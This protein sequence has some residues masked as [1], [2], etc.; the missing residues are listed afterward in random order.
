MQTRAL[1]LTIV[2][3]PAPSHG[4]GVLLWLASCASFCDPWTS[5]CR[6]TWPVP[7][8]GWLLP[9]CQS[10]SGCFL[11]SSRRT[12][13]V[14]M[15]SASELSASCPSEAALLS[16]P[17]R[18]HLTAHERSY[19]RCIGSAS[20]IC[21]RARAWSRVRAWSQPL[22]PNFRLVVQTVYRTCTPT[23]SQPRQRLSLRVT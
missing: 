8:Q 20:V 22:D 3:W 6:V 16:S 17:A 11:V 13:S 9:Q 23:P 1:N 18:P 2:P 10:G 12:R 15:S 21:P 14:H 5:G 7:A 19:S 4:C